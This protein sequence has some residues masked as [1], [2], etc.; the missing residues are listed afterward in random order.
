MELLYC[1]RGFSGGAWVESRCGSCVFSKDLND[2]SNRLY[3]AYLG[4]GSAQIQDAS[5]TPDA[6]ALCAP[7]LRGDGTVKF[8]A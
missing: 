2:F 7:R 5:G 8:H 3:V 4:L 1:V 6:F